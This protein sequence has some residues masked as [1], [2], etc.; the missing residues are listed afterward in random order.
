LSAVLENAP[1]SDFAPV[2]ELNRTDADIN[3]MFLYQKK[4]LEYSKPVNDPWFEANTPVTREYETDDINNGTK[5]KNVTVYTPSSPV[6]PLACTFQYQFCDPNASSGPNCTDL[7]GIMPA[8]DQSAQLF[9]REKQRDI[10][11]RMAEVVGVANSFKELI[12]N[13]KGNLLQINQYGF[14]QMAGLKDDYW[15]V[16]LNHMMATLMKLYQIRN[17]RYTGGY[18]APLN[19]KPVITS[20]LEKE[21]WMC[22]AQIVK[23]EDYQ[24]LSVL[25]LALII[26]I[27]ALIILINLTLDSFVGWYQR[28]YNKR[29]F[30]TREWELLQAETLQQQLY[31]AHGID[32]REDDVSIGTVLEKMENRRRVETF[33]TL[34][35]SEREMKSM[36]SS[37]SMD[38]GSVGNASVRRIDTERTMPVSPLSRHD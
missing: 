11:K 34:V 32:L 7:T 24:S 17:Y 36:S 35:D 15:T 8:Y 26:S 4:E 23:R 3:I 5:F 1:G 29:L 27:G 37:G 14:Y 25:G 20:P 30:A 21:R 31:K 18:S 6:L 10:G 2:S 33:A 9:K 19:Y 13:L 12:S 22:D 38:K 16:E 28:K